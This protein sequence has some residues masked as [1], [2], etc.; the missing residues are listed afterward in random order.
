M[1]KEQQYRIFR[2]YFKDGQGWFVNMKAR[3]IDSIFLT[4]LLKQYI[5]TK[6]LKI[7]K[8]HLN[9]LQI[10][11]KYLIENQVKL[12]HPAKCVKCKLTFTYRAEQ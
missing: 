8:D 4:K 6:G 11:Q 5:E 10:I 1:C 7:A 12:F 9:W 2:N 3:Q